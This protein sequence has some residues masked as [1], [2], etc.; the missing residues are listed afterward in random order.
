MTCTLQL[1][2]AFKVGPHALAFHEKLAADGPVSWNPGLFIDAPP[3]L[4][5]LNESDVAA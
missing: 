4:L 5:T 3:V 1:L 2:P